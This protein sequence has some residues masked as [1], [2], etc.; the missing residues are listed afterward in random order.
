MV[1]E[2]QSPVRVY[3]HPFELIMAVSDVLILR[4]LLNSQIV[5]I[6][7][8]AAFQLT[9]LNMSFIFAKYPLYTN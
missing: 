3:K 1:Q 2:Y 5:C 4:N 9:A 7:I 6:C 8:Y